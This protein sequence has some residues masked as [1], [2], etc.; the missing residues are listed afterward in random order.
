[1]VTIM[2]WENKSSWLSSLSEQS[3]WEI[4]LSDTGIADRRT[5]IQDVDNLGRLSLPPAID[6]DMDYFQWPEYWAKLKHEIMLLICTNDSKYRNLRRDL[7]ASGRKS[8]TAVISVIAAAMASQFGATVGVLVP[9]CA[10]CLIGVLRIGKEAFC[11]SYGDP[12]QK[13]VT[14]AQEL[15]TQKQRREKRK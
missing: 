5:R 7:S 12:C 13:R 4:A 1:M 6:G 8:Q 15:P 3:L 10:L 9:F 2:E 14:Q 11:A